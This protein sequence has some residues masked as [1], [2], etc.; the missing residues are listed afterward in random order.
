MLTTAAL[1]PGNASTLEALCEPSRRPA[2]PSPEVLQFRP[3]PRCCVQLST[4]TPRPRSCVWTGT[5]PSAARLLAMLRDPVPSLLPIPEPCMRAP[6]YVCCWTTCK[7]RVHKIA[8][9]VVLLWRAD[10][11]V[12]AFLD[13]LYVV[14]ERAAPLLRV[15]T[16]EVERGAGVNAARCRR[17]RPGR[18]VRQP[19][20]RAAWLRRSLRAHRL[21]RSG[22]SPSR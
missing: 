4:S 18:F 19:A 20:P 16:G 3:R 2:H 12:A 15:V 8:Q 17:L 6:P 11:R 5:T 14:P 1:A 7:R 10:G 21:P 22:S 13:D 9:A